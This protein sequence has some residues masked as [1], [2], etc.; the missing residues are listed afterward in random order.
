MPQTINTTTEN[1]FTKG[2]LTEYTGL[3]FPEDAA[4]DTDNCIYT[5]IG[6][7]TRREGINY[8][9]NFLLQNGIPREG[10]AVSTYKWNNVGGDGETQLIVAQI[11]ATLYFYSVTDA[12]VT[13]PLS[14]N[15]LASVVLLNQF[16]VNVGTFSPALECTYADGNGYLFVYNP[17]CD[18]FYITYS[19]GV[20]T[21]NAIP[22]QIRDF[23]G[24]NENIPANYRPGTL[25]AEHQ[26][27]ITNQGWTSGAA[28]NFSSTT[29]QEIAIGPMTFVGQTGLTV[30][31][32]QNIQISIGQIFFGGTPIFPSGTLV[33]AATV[34]SYNS[35]TGSLGINV[36]EILTPG[37]VGQVYST[38]T[39]VPTNTGYISTWQAAE[40]NYPS[41]ADVWWYYKD[42][43]DVFNPATTVGNVTLSSGNAPQGHYILSAF[44]QNRSVVSAIPGLTPIATNLRP[45]NGCWFQ[46]RVWYA[47]VNG[48]QPAQGDAP[49]Y[50]WTENIYFS[51]IVVSVDDFAQCYQTNDP[52][53]ETL[54][55]LLPTD[56]GV[57]NVVGSGQIY[58]LFPIQNGLLVFAA[59][60]VWFI[61]G[62]QGIGF[63]AD[64]YTIT[65]ISS[66]QS[67]SSTSFVDVLG[68][69][70][71]WN[72]EGIY[73]V[74]PS[75]GGALTVN[76][77]TVGSIQ[78]FYD[79]IPLESKQFAR[80]AYHPINYI[81]QWVWWSAD[82]N[83]YTY[84][85]VLNFNTYNKAFY[86]YTVDT[87]QASI[88][89]IQYVAGPGGSDSPAPVFKYLSSPNT[90]QGI[91]FAE[92]RDDV[93]WSDWQ[94]TGTGVNYVSYFTT[95]Y[96]IRGQAIKKFQPTY[97]IVYNAVNGAASAYKIQGIWDYANDPSS[98]R[99]SSQQVVTNGLTRYD[100]IMRRHKIRGHGY[101]LQFNITSVDGM[102]FDIQG[103]AT[104][105]TT[106]AGV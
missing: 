91:T 98:G 89:S 99:W 94:G 83:A 39:I 95:G 36:Y 90:L 45:T 12:T 58:K 80:G 17:N 9:D 5:L 74:E 62:S 24:I 43:T 84:D 59:N 64:D 101:V 8:E 27:N 14:A 63:T 3:N 92:E 53:S 35:G 103:W 30:T 4:T 88:N 60:G 86:P 44:N 97:I 11:G 48:S 51:Q 47:G 7:V 67:I 81:V 10:F 31:N 69:P 85:N 15:R 42:D 16:A 93:T 52:T 34:T 13:T 19:N 54:F 41:N 20:L 23:V 25:T 33:M 78:T 37:F 77:L 106:N 28:W 21:G 100:V 87:T 68:L 104:T 73:A 46:G 2:L 70:Y 22:I 56:G 105:D 29:S 96:R 72:E 75:Q 61:T 57:I 66:V 49:Y 18:P 79:S 40:G 6:D 76:S 1:K 65:K 55:N 71:F 50:T 32:G 82:Q 102:P 38:W 26:Y